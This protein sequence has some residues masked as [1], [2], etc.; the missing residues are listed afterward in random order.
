MIYMVGNSNHV[1]AQSAF[2]TGYEW[3]MPRPSQQATVIQKLGVTEIRVDYSRPSAKGRE[4]WGNPRVVPYGKVWR[5]GANE[6]TKISF[7]TDVMIDGQALE[8]GDYAFFIQPMESEKWRI[9]FNK[10]AI[11]WGAFTYNPDRDALVIELE[12][13]Q[14]EHREA[15]EYS[16]PI[17]TDTRALMSVHWGTKE[18][19]V[20]IEVDAINTAMTRADNTFDWQAGFFAAQFFIRNESNFEEALRWAN[21]SIAMEENYTNLN[22]KTVILSELERFEEAIEV[23]ERIIDKANAEESRQGNYFKRQMGIKISEWKA[24]INND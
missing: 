14:T 6:A 8:K 24:K 22:Q 15:L 10:D 13:Q 19:L 11:Q 5:A 21:A 4:I 3:V 20:P 9:I 17:V 18:I 1:I 16:F 7:D 23:G 12:P 2:K